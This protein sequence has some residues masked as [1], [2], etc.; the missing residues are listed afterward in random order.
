MTERTQRNR[1]GLKRR[2]LSLVHAGTGS[3]VIATSVLSPP[4]AGAGTRGADA[5]L[6]ERAAA[7]RQ[8]LTASLEPAPEGKTEGTQLAWWGNWH[9]WW[10]RWHPRWHNWPNWRNWHNWGNW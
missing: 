7:A 5:D 4:S 8:R 9:N 10:R 1:R 3:L 6:L 2:L